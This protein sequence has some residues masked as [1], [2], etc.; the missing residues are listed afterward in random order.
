MKKSIF[1]LILV[2]I[3]MFSFGVSAF[4]Q[5]VAPPTDRYGPTAEDLDSL[6]PKVSIDDASAWSE[7]KGYEVISFLQRVVQPFA[8][9]MFILFAFLVLVGAFGNGQLVSKG[10]WGMAIALVMYAVV[11]YAPEIM[12]VFLAWIIS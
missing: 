3:M 5:E 4:A 6:T 8:I 10:V 2:T 9:I 11:L 12:D 1:L 7:R